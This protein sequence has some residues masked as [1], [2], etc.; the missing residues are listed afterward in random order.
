MNNVGVIVIRGLYVT[1]W[2]I[3][4]TGDVVGLL[5]YSGI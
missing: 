3:I 5:L 2:C 1:M 4:G